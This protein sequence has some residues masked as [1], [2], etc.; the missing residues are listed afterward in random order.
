MAEFGRSEIKYT[1]SFNK[2]EVLILAECGTM[3]YSILELQEAFN[4]NINK[5]AFSKR[6]RDPEF[7]QK[8]TNKQS[9]TL[10]ETIIQNSKCS[11]EDITAVTRDEDLYK[12]ARISQIRRCLNRYKCTSIIE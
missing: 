2:K 12:E 4:N 1:N 7:P 5:N 10:T 6:K 11:T 3:D 9:L 8:D